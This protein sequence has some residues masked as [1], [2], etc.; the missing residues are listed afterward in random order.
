VLAAMKPGESLLLLRAQ[1]GR[2][3]FP[4]AVARA[5]HAVEIVAVYETR[6]AHGPEPRIVEML[7]GGLI[8]AVTFSSASTVESFCALV[9]GASRAKALLGRT[10]VA[11]IGPI[12]SEALAARGVRVDVTPAQ[13]TLPALLAALEAAF[14]SP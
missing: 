11:S 12:T 6:P 4:D 14:G 3:A 13:T 5:G 8:D 7:E 9:G 1:A 2:D 10:L